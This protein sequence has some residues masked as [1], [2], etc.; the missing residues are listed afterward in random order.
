[1]LGT[2]AALQIRLALN[3]DLIV[4]SSGGSLPADVRGGA[5][6]S[7]HAAFILCA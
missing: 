4:A 2:H 1:M 5:W 6:R 3:E 7:G